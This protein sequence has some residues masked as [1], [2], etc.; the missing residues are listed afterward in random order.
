[1]KCRD[2]AVWQANMAFRWEPDSPP[3]QIE[4]HSKAKLEVLRKY[5][6]AYFDTLTVK[7]Q[8]E[9]F[10]LDPV[11]GFCGGDWEIVA[12]MRIIRAT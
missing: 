6:R 1:M 11:D 5:L 2:M 7:P 3:P 4:A 8:Q 9:A 10:K 12:T